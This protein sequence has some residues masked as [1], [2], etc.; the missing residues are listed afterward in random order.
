LKIALDALVPFSVSNERMLMLMRT[1]AMDAVLIE[2][3]I[4]SVFLK[5]KGIDGSPG[6]ELFLFCEVESCSSFLE[7]KL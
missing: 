6:T 5:Y 7:S 1:A 4:L 2:I 3:F